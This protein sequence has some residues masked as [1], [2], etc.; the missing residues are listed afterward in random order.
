MKMMSTFLTIMMIMLMMTLMTF[1]MSKK[2]IMDREKSS[3]FE[4][5]FSSMSSP[6]MSFSIHFFMIAIIF[7]IF[8]IE[9]TLILPIVYS[10]KMMNMKEWF[11]SSTMII[12]L[13]TYGLYHEWMN[14]IIEWSK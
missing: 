3:Q 7:L 14:G 8:D 13:I 2:S 4:C 1:L 10:A 6:R 11:M 9:M 5:G 12:T